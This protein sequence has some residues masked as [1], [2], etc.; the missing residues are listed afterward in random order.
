[1]RARKGFTLIELLVVIA[2]IAILAAILFPVFAKARAKARQSSC[3]SNLKQLGLAFMQYQTD[4][5]GCLPD[6][7]VSYNWY[8]SHPPGNYYGADHITWWSIRLWSDDTQTALAGS[9]LTLN[10][11][12]KNQNLWI[13]PADRREGRWISGMQRHSYY[14][15][16]ALDVEASIN[17]MSIKEDSFIRP[18]QI[19]M[20]IEEAWHDSASDPYLWNGQTVPTKNCNAA[21]VDGHAK[22][23]KVPFVGATGSP[24]YDINWFFYNAGQ[25]LGN[26][27]YDVP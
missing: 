23:L 2:I 3:V 9:A 4:Y 20:L 24:N 17:G 11:Y 26:D 25:L 22:I 16:H 8:A 12:I 27:P 19:A 15:R 7:R 5:D 18:A 21:F 14:F 6:S 1:V 13:C 10:P